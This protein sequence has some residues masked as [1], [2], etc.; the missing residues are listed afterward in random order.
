[1]ALD[2]DPDETLLFDGRM[3]W[4]GS[5]LDPGVLATLG[6]WAIARRYGSRYTV[7]DKRVYRRFGII[8]KDED[9]I[10]V[11]DIRDVSMK[12]GYIGRL[13]KFG[14]VDISTAG[15]ARI[16]VDFEKVDEPWDAMEAIESAIEER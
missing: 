6:L 16:E 3:S 2:I 11:D 9:V 14:D 5:L 1:M 7:T 12:Q 8:R 4:V 15:R 13:A 10:R